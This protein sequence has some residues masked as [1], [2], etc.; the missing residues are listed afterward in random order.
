MRITDEPKCNRTTFQG[1]ILH[2]REK[3]KTYI[4]S[5]KDNC[6]LY[7]HSYRETFVSTRRSPTNIGG[8]LNEVNRRS[9]PTDREDIKVGRVYDSLIC[10]NIL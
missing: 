8:M 5:R 9:D 7:R 6:L 10:F 4:A 3:T 2:E 1:C